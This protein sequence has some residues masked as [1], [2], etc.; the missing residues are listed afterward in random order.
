VIKVAIGLALVAAMLGWLLIKAN[1]QR[2]VAMAANEALEVQ[3]GL[4]SVAH[5]EAMRGAENERQAYQAAMRLSAEW[6]ADLLDQ[7]IESK[8]NV[9]GATAL[10][11]DEEFW[12]ASEPTPSIV[13]AGVR[14]NAAGRR[15]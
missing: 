13:V 5:D 11:S 12:C 3:I 15:N 4:Q 9:E 8:T 14:A 2:A 10:M 7:L 6:R 1:E